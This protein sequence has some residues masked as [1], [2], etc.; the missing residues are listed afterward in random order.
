M[1]IVLAGMM[2]V[3]ESPNFDMTELGASRELFILAQRYAK[4]SNNLIT[5]DREMSEQDYSSELLMVSEDHA[6]N[7]QQML[8]HKMIEMKEKINSFDAPK[9]IESMKQL[10]HLHE[11]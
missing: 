3:M 6:L 9:Y 1:G 11:E 4:I 2:D 7:E 5:F 8:L 10:H